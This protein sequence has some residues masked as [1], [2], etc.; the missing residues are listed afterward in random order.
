MYGSGSL[1]VD[2]K[3]DALSSERNIEINGGKFILSGES[4]ISAQKNM[5]VNGGN[6]SITASGNGDGIYIREGSKELEQRSE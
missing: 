6:I 2:A 5:T 1:T 4:G 3:S